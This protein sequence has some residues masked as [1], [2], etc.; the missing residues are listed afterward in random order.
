MQITLHILTH[1]HAQAIMASWDKGS[2]FDD[3]FFLPRPVR[4]W[5]S[6]MLGG[7]RRRYTTA[8][9]NIE[10]REVFLDGGVFGLEPC[11]RYIT[12]L[13]WHMKHPETL[14]RYLCLHEL[15]CGWN[16]RLALVIMHEIGHIYWRCGHT[17]RT[18][19]LMFPSWLG[20][21]WKIGRP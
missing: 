18:G 11:I 1:R 16:K 19:Y 9:C 8:W 10:T 12:V 21:G 5:L 7:I 20:R 14:G 13:D 15:K 2:W 3:F 6:R 17:F 4:R